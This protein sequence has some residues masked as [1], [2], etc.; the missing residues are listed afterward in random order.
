MKTEKYLKEKAEEDLN[1]QKTSRME[2][3]GSQFNEQKTSVKSVNRKRKIAVVSGMASFAAACCAVVLCVTFVNR[4]SGKITYSEANFITEDISLQEVND[5]LKCF[6]METTGFNNDC[7]LV[8]DSVSGDG[9]YYSVSLNIN[10]VSRYMNLK[11]IYVINDNYTYSGLDM[12]EFE[13]VV[14]DDYTINYNKIQ[15][16]VDEE[17]TE[18]DYVGTV[19]NGDETIYITNCEQFSMTDDAFFDVIQSVVQ[20]R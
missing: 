18:Y 1:N 17:Y 2:M 16:S 7:V 8:K 11:F 12:Y 20:S 14:F 9:I 19:T 10:D 6:S 4:Q 15:E 3:F 5:C 13:S